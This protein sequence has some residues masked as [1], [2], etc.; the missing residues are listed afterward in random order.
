MSRQA[1]LPEIEVLESIGHLAWPALEQATV[2]GWLVR[3]AGGVTRRSNSVNPDRPPTTDLDDAVTAGLA[4]LAARDLSPIFRLT[5]ASPPELG[6]L[7]E[8]RG[9]ARQPGGIILVRDLTAAAVPRSVEMSPSRSNEW[10]DVLARQADRGGTSRHIVERLL[11]GHTAPTTYALIRLRD[12]PASIGMAVVI[13]GHV[14]I[15][16]MYTADSH[17]RQGLGRTVL[18][19]LLAFG[20]SQGASRAFLQV[21][22][23]NAAARALYGSAG[24]ESRYQ[25]WYYQEPDRP[26]DNDVDQPG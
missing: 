2:C 5:P 14:A 10:T 25:Y 7:L 18:D 9:L 1:S 20:H 11:D 4:W 6:P 23:A 24:F 8:E 26:S 3:A 12:R 21:H 16:N 22:P 19:A 15:F 17:R 13:E